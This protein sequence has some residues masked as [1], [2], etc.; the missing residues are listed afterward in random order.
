MDK[1]TVRSRSASVKAAGNIDLAGVVAVTRDKAS[2]AL[3]VPFDR[4]DNAEKEIAAAAS[5]PAFHPMPHFARVPRG[6]IGVHMGDDYPGHYAVVDPRNLKIEDGAVVLQRG[7]FDD[8]PPI[9]SKITWSASWKRWMITTGFQRPGRLYLSDTASEEFLHKRIIGRAVGV[10]AAN[11]EPLR[12][13]WPLYYY[14]LPP[15]PEERVIDPKSLPDFYGAKVVGDCLDP[16]LK[17]GDLARFD[18]TVAVNR[19]DLIGIWL[20]PHLVTNR[21]KSQAL[22]KM[23]VSGLTKQ[24]QARLPLPD[25]MPLPPLMFVQTLNPLC[26]YVVPLDQVAAIVKCT[27]E[28]TVP[29]GKPKVVQRPRSR[30]RREEGRIAAGGENR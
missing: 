6:M 7:V 17:D 11:G 2:M 24:L 23:L 18:R 1:T 13:L 3:P 8:S 22:V 20:K 9:F 14:R 12:E 4:T 10:L 5:L 28:A 29:V 16:V 30:E 27:G 26:T 19:H 15:A 25:D 21:V